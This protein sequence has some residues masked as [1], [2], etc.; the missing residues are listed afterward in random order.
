[1]SALGKLNHLSLSV[2]CGLLSSSV[3]ACTRWQRQ[4]ISPERVVSEM[5]PSRILVTRSDSAR[6]ELVQPRVSG[7]SLIGSVPGRAVSMPLS[8]VATVSV[9]KG[10]PGATIALVLGIGGVALAAFFAWFA[11]ASGGPGS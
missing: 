2:A 3:I 10:N 9:R 4:E 11:A 5:K 8:A 6:V 1:M 7:D